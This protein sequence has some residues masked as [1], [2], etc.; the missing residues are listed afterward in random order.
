[1]TSPETL[2][3]KFDDNE[4]S[5]LLFNHMVDSDARFDSCGILKS[6]QGDELI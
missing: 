3:M 4:L 2:N 6:G 1:M 5:F